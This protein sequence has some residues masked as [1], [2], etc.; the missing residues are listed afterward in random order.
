MLVLCGLQAIKHS[1]AINCVIGY[2]LISSS[3][4]QLWTLE[5]IWTVRVLWTVSERPE[6]GRLRCSGRVGGV[7]ILDAIGYAELILNG[8]KKTDQFSS[9]RVDFEIGA[10]TLHEKS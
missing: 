1:C 3:S 4:V 8:R 6:S 7:Q 10:V 2:F 9:T 5:M